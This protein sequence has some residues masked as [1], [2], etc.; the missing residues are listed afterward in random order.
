[1]TEAN[2]KTLILGFDALDFRYLDRFQ[3]SLPHFRALRNRGLEAPLDSTFPPWTASAWPSM[4]TGM[5]PS[6]HG[7]YDFF[8]I[9]GYPDKAQLVTNRDVEQPAIWDYLTAQGARSIVLNVPVTHPAGELNGVLIPGYLASEDATG[10]PAT[11]RDEVSNAVGEPYRI[12]SRN[13]AESGT[14]QV[15]DYTDLIDLRKQ[16]AIHLLESREWDFSFIQV[17]KTDNVFH[18]FDDESAFRRVYEAADELLGAVL[19]TV[20]DDVN[21]IVCSDHGMGR[22]NGYGIYLNEILREHGY[23]EIGTGGTGPQLK[24]VKRRFK[25]SES[26]DSENRPLPATA[27]TWFVEEFGE[28]LP[29]GSLYTVLENLGIADSVSKMVPYT[30]RAAASDGID[31][32]KSTA[33]CRSSSRLGVRINLRNRD[34]QGVVPESDY[35]RVRDDI[36]ALL[37]GVKTPDGRDAF[38]DVSRREAVYDGPYSERADDILVTPKGMNNGIGTEL[39]GRQFISID[40]Y[41]HKPAGVFLADGPAFEAD[42]SL[43]RLSL[44][45]VAPT[46]MA[47]LKQ[48]VPDRMTGTVPNGLLTRSIETAQY[49]DLTIDFA[50]RE[51]TERG[52]EKEKT[53]EERLENLGYL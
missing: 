46:A 11:I 35:E 25:Q 18:S 16:A 14:V 31:W 41:D 43:G 37:T 5:D 8:T 29:I 26:T 53:M 42:T 10:Y 2:S 50:G 52:A 17:Q 30:S 27:V 22:K 9:G 7:V 20:S 49:D 3:G 4:Y 15:S 47:V 44:T 13:E 48:P 39:F 36:I 34:P 12:Y 45:D 28:H 19:D 33:Y 6:Y 51:G 38:E 32:A 21:V 24:H 40:T 1:M 23:I